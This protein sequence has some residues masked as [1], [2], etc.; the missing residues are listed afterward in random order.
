M[1]VICFDKVKEDGEN[2]I[3]GEAHRRFRK[4]VRVTRNSC[5]SPRKGPGCR[6]RARSSLNAFAACKPTLDSVGRQ[7]LGIGLKKLP[8]QQ[9]ES[10]QC[11]R[12]Y[13]VCPLKKAPHRH[14][15]MGQGPGAIPPGGVFSLSQ[16][17]QRRLAHC[18]QLRPQHCCC[19]MA[20][21]SPP[22]AK[23]AQTF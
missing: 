3:S 12:R 4:D 20:L 16:R 8:D 22:G 21:S 7:E 19:H 6:C 17:F 18:G 2:C 10:A 15:E 9:R 11:A 23:E 5:P 14:T 1:S 13:K